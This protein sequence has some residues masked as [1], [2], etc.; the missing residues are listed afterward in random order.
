MD[1][2]ASTPLAPEWKELLNLS[3]RR[4]PDFYEKS[5]EIGD[6][7]HAGALRTTLDGLG[8]SA[9]FCVQDVPTAVVVSVDQYVPEDA[10]KLQA[11]LW[12]QGLASLLLFVSEDTVRVFSLARTPRRCT[13]DEFHSHCLV[14]TLNAATDALALGN[15]LYS[16]ESGRYWEAYAQYFRP[17]ERVDRVLLNNLTESDRLLR[18][19]GLPGDASQALLLQAM[20]VAYL[21]D[22]EIIGEEYI[23][24]ATNEGTTDFNTPLST[25]DV[26]SLERLFAALRRDFNGDLFIAPCSFDANDPGPSLEASH[27]EILARFRSGREEMHGSGGQYRLWPYNFKYIPVELISAVHDRFLS[28]RGDADRRLRGAYYTPMLLADV[29]V[30]HMWERLPAEAKEGGTFLDPACGSGIFLVRLFQRLCECRRASRPEGRIPWSALLDILMR[31]RGWDL[32]GGAVRVAVFSLYVALLEEVTPP[33]IRRLMKRGR[34]LPELHGQTLRCADFF[35]VAPEAV[36]VDVVVGNPPWSSRHGEGHPAFEWCRQA[37]LPMPSGEQAWSFLWKS[38]RHLRKDGLVALLLPAMGFLHNHARSAVTARRRLMREARVF[39][40]VNFADMRFQLF[41]R[42]SRPTS[43]FLL[44]RSAPGDTD[45]RF[46]YLTPRADPNLKARRLITVSSVDRCRLESRV[47][48]TDPSVFKKRLWMSE[49]EARLFDYL[50][51][52]PSVGDVVGQYG[53]LLRRKRPTEGGWVIGQGFK[54]AK[55]ER[56]TDPAYEQEQSAIVAATPYLPINKFCV[57]I[58]TGA[59]LQPWPDGMVHRR[60]FQRGFKGP[61]I[62]IPRGVAVGEGGL[63]LRAAYVETPLTFQHIIQAIAV[64][65]GEENQGM[66]LTALLNSKLMLWFAFHGTSSFGADRPE[67]QQAELLR[68]PFPSPDDMPDQERSRSAAEALVGKMKGRLQAAAATGRTDAGQSGVL[69]EVDRL[70]LEYFCLSEEDRIVV[71]DTVDHVI[72]AVQPSRGSFPAL[73]RPSTESDRSEYA[74]ILVGSLAEYFEGGHSIGARLVARSEDLAVLRLS[75]RD[76]T[77]AFD[78]SEDENAS[79]AAA[80]SGLAEAVR[81]RLPAN[82]Q[83]APDF[84]VFVGRELFLVKPVGRRF[85]LRSRALADVR[86]I[87]LDLH[88]ASGRDAPF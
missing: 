31:L 2:I 48:E 68:L 75:L 85:W 39:S 21:E 34:V 32:D 37:R 56:G 12:N 4:A 47:V 49:P 5:A 40:V 16:A 83:T 66:L 65:P 59:G 25:G 41:D 88:M 6:V 26:G 87:A 58:E 30:S 9:V 67:V 79:V 81:Q 33:D 45:Y 42:A 64:P 18:Q 72:P 20:F 55:T 82:F 71:D 23:R 10:A 22:R 57:L 8:A 51:R 70:A 86:A 14:Q 80:V 53:T 7:S 15:L 62:L 50:S 19:E 76:T 73:W 74:R 54:P 29:V 38:L 28:E 43:L 1:A 52:L 78:Y 77:V 44:G 13:D 63:R 35:S 60:G 27:L 46:D 69:E 36:E 84:R 24:A 3:L 11:A 61:R 17:E